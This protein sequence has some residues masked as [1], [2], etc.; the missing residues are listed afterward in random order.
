MIAK[1]R[2]ISL[3]ICTLLAP[4]VYAETKTK[5]DSTT[6][7]MVITGVKTDTPLS[8]ET[9]PKAPRQPLPAQD[10]ADYLK[11]IPGFSVIRK[12]G[13]SG[14]PVFRGMAGSRLSLLLDG[15]LVLGGCGSRMDPPT[16][17]VF[18]ETYDRIRL[19]KGPQTVIHGPG[20]SAGVVLFE[21]DRERL[22][23][24]GWKFHSSL[25][26]GSFGRDDEVID[27]QGGT[28]DFYLRGMASHSQQDNYEDGDGNEVHSQYDRWNT[29]LT[30]GWT[31]SDD[32]IVE[33]NGSRSDAEAAYADRS[34]DGSKFARDNLSAKLIVKN[35]TPVWKKLETQIYYNYVDHVM[36]N[37]SLRKLTGMTT[38]Q[39]ASNPDRQ[40]EG[41]R[42]LATLNP[43]SSAELILGADTQ[44]NDHTNRSTSNQMMMPYQDM[45]RV[46]DAYFKQLGIFGEWTQTLSAQQRVISGLRFDDWNAEDQRAANRMIGNVQYT[47]PT[48]GQER[49]E[50]LSSGF[51][52]YEKDMR[53][54]TLYTGIGHSERFPDYWELISKESSESISAFNAKPEET[55]Q[56][57]IGA[58]YTTHRL[59][60][61]MSMFYSEID[62]YLLIQSRVNKPAGTTGSRI[63]TVTRNVDASTWGLEADISYA[64]TDSWRT[65]ASLASTRGT[66]ETDNTH[67]SQ[68]PPLELRLGLNYTNPTWSAGVFWRVADDQTRVDVNKGNI[69][70]QDI[71]TS[72]GFNVLSFNSGWRAHKNLLITSGIDNLL[73]E[74]YAEHISKAG[75]MIAGYDQTTRIN[76]PGRTYWLKAQLT[77]E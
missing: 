59:K 32:V 19:V 35:L 25:L 33:I 18:P 46:G 73:N 1:P 5:N 77:F 36:D 75:A 72:E 7:E 74:T 39:M 61:S 17:Y 50:N 9:D 53:P 26:D 64:I 43:T 71:G 28:P 66:N 22:A 3:A 27:L 23:E 47:N 65:E 4:W 29:N 38:M 56:L 14:D 37:Y 15:D 63:A 76:E 62:N 60:S 20:N 69:A 52:R 30:L 49:N 48:A 67:L 55:T 10:G 12:G 44:T 70:G 2:L 24:P 57:D 31:P 11:T 42:V 68:I 40:T 41:A 34:M 13:T 6:E 51:L 45:P 54:I 16:A 58:I 21:R 8:I